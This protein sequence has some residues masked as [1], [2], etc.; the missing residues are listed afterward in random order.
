MFKLHHYCLDFLFEGGC[1]WQIYF[2]FSYYFFHY[3][4][5]ILIW[6]VVNFKSSA[7]TFRIFV[8]QVS[9]FDEY[10]QK[11]TNKR[12]NVSKL[13]CWSRR[14]FQAGFYLTVHFQ[15]VN[16]STLYFSGRKSVQ[17]HAVWDQVH[18]QKWFDQAHQ[19][20]QMSQEN[21]HSGGWN[22]HQEAFQNICHFQ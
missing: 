3:F 1:V 6:N 5:F 2:L 21:N 14:L 18:L 10:R 17:L 20:E 13:K 15:I 16:R 12:A 4:V 11:S 7:E 22:H 9:N 19:A 8:P